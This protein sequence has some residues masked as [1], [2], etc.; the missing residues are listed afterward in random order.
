MPLQMCK[1]MFPVRKRF[2]TQHRA[3]QLLQ[4]LGAFL[5]TQMTFSSVWANEKLGLYE[6]DAE[7]PDQYGLSRRR[8]VSPDDPANKDAE[9]LYDEYRPGLRQYIHALSAGSYRLDVSRR[10]VTV[11]F[12]AGDSQDRTA[13]FVLR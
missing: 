10:G 13:R 6:I 7:G 2:C 3:S 11:D 4:M 5:F 9:A 8:R 1:D 12:Y